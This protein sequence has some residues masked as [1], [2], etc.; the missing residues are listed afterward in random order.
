LS[1]SQFSQRNVPLELSAILPA[2]VA[3]I[4]REESIKA[5]LTTAAQRAE[6]PPSSILVFRSLEALF[7]DFEAVR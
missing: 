4:D 1:N 3:V 6:G 7:L 5:T 2:V